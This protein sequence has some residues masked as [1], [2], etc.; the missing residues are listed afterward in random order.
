MNLQRIHYDFCIKPIFVKN[1]QEY[2][3]EGL[4]ANEK[5]GHRS[6]NY[7]FRTIVDIL[8]QYFGDDLEFEFDERGNLLKITTLSHE[9][10]QILRLIYEDTCERPI[11]YGRS[12][13]KFEL[14]GYTV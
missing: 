1:G 8:R 9:Q 4:N 14:C 12:H 10:M 5:G 13:L 2:A 7:E 3:F 6:R 11:K